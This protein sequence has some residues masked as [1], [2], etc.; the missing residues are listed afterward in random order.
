MWQCSCGPGNPQLIC[1]HSE[2]FICLK[3]G[4]KSWLHRYGREKYSRYREQMVPDVV[5]NV[6][7]ANVE[8]GRGRC[9]GK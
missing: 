1:G 7:R 5:L 4:Q 9:G 8:E 2:G 3:K 6:A